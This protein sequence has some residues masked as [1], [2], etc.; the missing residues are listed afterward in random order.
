MKRTLL[1]LSLIAGCSTPITK[2]EPVQVLT[3][4]AV[5]P[6]PPSVEVPKMLIP[7]L[8]AQSTDGQVAIA[9]LHDVRALRYLVEQYELIINK[10]RELA[11]Q[12][13]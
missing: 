3:P 10:Y 7:Q 2:I 8:T 9:Y 6:S 5:I 13:K 4:V 1:L 11:A 12:L